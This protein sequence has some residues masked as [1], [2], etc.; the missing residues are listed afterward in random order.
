MLVSV[1]HCNV[2][3]LCH[4]L[5]GRGR[6]RRLELSHSLLR[7]WRRPRASPFIKGNVLGGANALG[8]TSFHMHSLGSFEVQATFEQPQR[9]RPQGIDVYGYCAIVVPDKERKKK[10]NCKYVEKLKIK[11]AKTSWPAPLCSSAG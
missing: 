8:K 2:S 7:F 6:V 11:T 1:D 3:P 5:S 4:E 10:K 9:R